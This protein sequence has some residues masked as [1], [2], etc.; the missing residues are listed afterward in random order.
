MNAS[1]LIDIV[2]GAL[3]LA[4]CVLVV[5]GGAG[6]LRFQDFYT[7]THAGSLTDAGGAG[8]LLLGLLPQ[9]ESWESAVRL[10]LILLFLM[11]TSPTAA[12]ALAQ[13]ARRDGERLPSADGDR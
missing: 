2:G 5:S 13:A 3:V 11:L 10:V 8:L 12:H 1:L 4:G 9:V 6:L 7:R